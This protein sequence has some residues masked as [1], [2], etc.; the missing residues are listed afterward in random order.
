MINFKN[1]R[2]KYGSIEA[3][4]NLS[5]NINQGEFVY[6]VGKSG[7]GKSTIIKLITREEMVT[8]G[9]VKVGNVQVS[10]IRSRNVYKLR[11]QIGVVNQKD[12]FLYKRTVE[13]NFKI[14]LEAIN[15]NTDL[16]EKRISDVLSIIDMYSYRQRFPKQLSIGQQ[17]KIAIARAIL[18]NPKIVVADEPTANLD[19]TSAVEVMRL[20]FKINQMGTTILMATHD[21]TIVNTFPHRVLEIDH[22]KLI[23]DQNYGKYNVFS[24]AKDVY[25]L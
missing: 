17:K 1:V 9:I 11:R 2:K 24:D 4:E 16:W 21:S 25:L 22:G 7:A 14:V 18:N 20:L 8:K 19:A 12:T 15:V 6:L 23:R 10:K 3:L 13:E 5:F